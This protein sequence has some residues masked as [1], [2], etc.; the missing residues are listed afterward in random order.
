MKLP[1]QGSEEKRIFKM[2]SRQS[3]PFDCLVQESSEVA[4][5]THQA[6]AFMEIMINVFSNV[7]TWMLAYFFAEHYG[8]LRL[9]H[10]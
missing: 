8:V 4:L 6:E 2:L 3:F 1:V 10:N 9:L 7:L 5:G